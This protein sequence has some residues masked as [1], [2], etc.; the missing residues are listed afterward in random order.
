MGN[1]LNLNKEPLL[2]FIGLI[3]KGGYK[4]CQ[5]GIFFIQAAGQAQGLLPPG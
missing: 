3:Y 2:A 5:P 4:L 1:S